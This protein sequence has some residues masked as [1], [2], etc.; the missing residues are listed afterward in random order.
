M[1]KT[2][3][4][5][6]VSTITRGKNDHFNW[7]QMLL[8]SRL[9]QVTYKVSTWGKQTFFHLVR[10]QPRIQH[11]L[12]G[13][14]GAY[15]MTPPPPPSQAGTYMH[16]CAR[17]RAHTPASVH[18]PDPRPYYV[19]CRHIKVWWLDLIYT[20][21]FKHNTLYKLTAQMSATQ[22]SGNLRSKDLAASGETAVK[23]QSFFF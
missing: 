11:S 18:P 9:Y 7:R 21:T 20:I 16:T 14:G 8:C 22:L 1:G 23:A 4:Y 12:G 2:R 17:A 13:G 6:H 10:I 15:K 3:R 5:Q 19:L